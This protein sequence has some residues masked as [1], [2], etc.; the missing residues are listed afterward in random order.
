MSLIR[1]NTILMNILSETSIPAQH[2]PVIICLKNTCN[3]AK[4]KD[5]GLQDT[6]TD[7]IRELLA[8]NHRYGYA[9]AVMEYKYDGFN[10]A[11]PWCFRK[12]DLIGTTAP[13][14]DKSI[15]L[16]EVYSWA[17]LNEIG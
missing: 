17:Y 3:I 11:R 7:N 6:K 4:S 15:P 16:F 13:T 5:A 2:A 8:A 12:L 1:K 10:I 14:V 9:I